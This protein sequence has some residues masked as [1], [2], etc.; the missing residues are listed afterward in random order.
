M[1]MKHERR[2]ISDARNWGLDKN[3]PEMNAYALGAKMP[4]GESSPQTKCFQKQK[5]LK[6]GTDRGGTQPPAATAKCLLL[7]PP[8]QPTAVL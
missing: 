2:S 8:S 7:I 6:R 5:P 4:V 1:P 3:K